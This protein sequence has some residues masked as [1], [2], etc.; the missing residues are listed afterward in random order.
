MKPSDP[1]EL[2]DPLQQAAESLGRLLLERGTER[3]V[4][5]ESCTAG[6]AAAALASV[7]GISQCLCG[8]LVTYREASKAAW[9][10][11]DAKLI[12]EFTAVS[13]QVTAAMA[14]GALQR[15][16]EADWAAAVT[17]HLG[18]GAPT[19]ADGRVYVAVARRVTGASRLTPEAETPPVVPASIEVPTELVLELEQRLTVG[20]RVSRQQQAAE[21]VLRALEQAIRQASRPA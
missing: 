19:E 20:P 21:H 15:T 5:A 3:V 2:A 6:L 9:L 1:L 7:P 16:I 14:R 13:R 17:G 11:V 18:P 10:G 8:S 12:A 4:F